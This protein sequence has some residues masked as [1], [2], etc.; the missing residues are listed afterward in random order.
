MIKAADERDFLTISFHSPLLHSILQSSN[1]SF[2]IVDA[3][4]AL[5]SQRHPESDFFFLLFNF[6]KQVL[7]S[8]SVAFN[9]LSLLNL[10]QNFD[11]F[12]EISLDFSNLH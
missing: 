9:I 1:F 3:Y 5:P 4:D 8:N 6:L 7:C 11:I 10:A 12:S 2:T